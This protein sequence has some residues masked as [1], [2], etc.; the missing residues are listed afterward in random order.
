MPFQGHS[1]LQMSNTLSPPEI[2]NHNGSSIS[3]RSN[4]TTRLRTSPLLKTNFERT[5]RKSD[6]EK[7]V[8]TNKVIVPEIPNEIKVTSS[9]DKVSFPGTL[10]EENK[11]LKQRLK[12]L[13]NELNAI[14]K[15]ITPKNRRKA[16]RELE[17]IS[18]MWGRQFPKICKDIAKEKIWRYVK[19]INDESMLDDYKDPSSIGYLF[20]SFY[21]N[22][23]TQ[24]SG[25]INDIWDEAK[26]YVSEAVAAKRNAIQTRI[27]KNFRGNLFI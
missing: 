27:K 21:R 24:D 7:L 1:M 20:L 11:F 26:D 23:D 9:Y 3:S 25:K 16:R 19:F 6:V 4:Q 22:I 18:D 13:Q 8:P 10:L 15:T 12:L 14:K 2:L 5:P 17:K